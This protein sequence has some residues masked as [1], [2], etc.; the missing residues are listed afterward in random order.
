MSQVAS[1]PDPMPSHTTL[2][3]IL[4]TL[5]ICQLSFSQ[6]PCLSIS[7]TPNY[8]SG[9]LTCPNLTLSSSIIYNHPWRISPLPSGPAAWTGNM[10]TTSS[11]T[12][13]M[14]TFLQMTPSGVPS[15]STAMIMIPLATQGISRLINLSP[16]NSGGWVSHNLCA[17]ILRAALNASK[18][19]QTLT[20]LS[21]HLP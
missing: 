20:P 8:M 16:P 5:T 15:S 7:L 18:T 10:M 14:S 4:T 2:T 19:N 12:K 11:P 9:S 17:S 6:T 13:D 21:P 3:S 1:L